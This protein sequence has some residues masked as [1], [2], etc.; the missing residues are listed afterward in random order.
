MSPFVFTCLFLVI[1]GTMTSSEFQGLQKDLWL[2]SLIRRHITKEEH[3]HRLTAQAHFDDLHEERAATPQRPYTPRKPSINRPAATSTTLHYNTARP[4]NNSR[5]NLYLFIQ[6]EDPFLY[7]VAVC[8]LR[9]LYSQSSG[10]VPGI[11][12]QLLQT[13]RQHKGAM[14]NFT[15]PDELASIPFQDPTLQAWWYTILRGDGENTPSLLHY[16]T[17]DPP[18][19][20]NQKKINLLFASPELRAAIFQD[21]T[22]AEQLDTILANLW[23]VILEEKTS[24][25]TEK[26]TRT[27]I[28]QTLQKQV[29]DLIEQSHLPTEMRKKFDFTMGKSGDVIFL[30]DPLTGKWERRRK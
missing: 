18:G 12:I 16:I 24:I 22:V 10:Y 23:R 13:L 4:P 28:R 7:D 26:I 1:I 15:T 21:A 14:E 25:E 2:Q 29:V 3:L 17:Y 8:L 11:E 20:M 30:Q 19:T 27:K 6:E 5:L 9:N